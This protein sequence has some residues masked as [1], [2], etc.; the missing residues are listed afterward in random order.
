MNSPIGVFSEDIKIVPIASYASANSDRNSEVIDTEG[1][2]RCCVVV[3]HAAIDDSTTYDIYLASSD[4]VTDQNT[5]S[6]GANVAGSSQTVDGEDDNDAK[7]FDFIPTKRYYQVVFNKDASLTSAE[8]A[9][10]YLY[11]SKDRPVTQSSGNTVVGEGT[12]AVIGEDIGA[13][14]QGT[15]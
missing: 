1:F 6:S 7:Y 15:K 13:A 5:L 3:H 11:H 2:G 8:S 10:A 9:V 4:A 12:G 14:I